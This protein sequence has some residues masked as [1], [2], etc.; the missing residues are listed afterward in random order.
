MVF[1]ILWNRYNRIKYLDY[2]QFCYKIVAKLIELTN[3]KI[4]AISILLIERGVFRSNYYRV[5]FSNLIKKNLTQE[6]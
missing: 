4:G 2:F 6:K 1:S 3:I 5:I